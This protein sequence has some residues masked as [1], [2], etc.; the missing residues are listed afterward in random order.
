LGNINNPL[1]RRRRRRLLVINDAAAGVLVMVVVVRMRVICDDSL[2]VVAKV[3][4]DCKLLV[5]DH[6]DEYKVETAFGARRLMVV[7]PTALGEAA[8][9]ARPEEK[10]VERV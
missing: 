9:A 10:K 5:N 2:Q 3:A 4:T 1:R 7:P 8:V 6:L